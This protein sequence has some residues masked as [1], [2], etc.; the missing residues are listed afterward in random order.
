MSIMVVI[1]NDVDHIIMNISTVIFCFKNTVSMR[2]HINQIIHR[3]YFYILKSFF[4]HH[5]TNSNS[6]VICFT[7]NIHA[8]NESYNN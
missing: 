2:V 5:N 4:K 6:F 1:C 8:M 7:N 3:L